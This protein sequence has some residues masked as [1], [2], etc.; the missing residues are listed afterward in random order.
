MNVCHCN[1]P[2][3]DTSSPTRRFWCVECGGATSFGRR[4]SLDETRRL[5]DQAHSLL[6]RILTDVTY[7]TESCYGIQASLGEG[8]RPS[9][10]SDPTGRINQQ[11][12][13]DA[14][15]LLALSCQ[16]VKQSV[17]WLANADEAAGLALYTTDPH[18]GPADHVKAPFHDSIPANRPDLARAHDARARRQGRGEL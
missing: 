1:S 18:R 11:R 3:R 12:R 14:A 15:V 6:D 8:G 10:H 4:L 7:A 16:W 9:G 2:V 5:V 13:S 17:A